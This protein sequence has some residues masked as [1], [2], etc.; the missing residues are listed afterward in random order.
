MIMEIGIKGISYSV[1]ERKYLV[2][3]KKDSKRVY[4][5]RYSSLEEAK[6]ALESYVDSPKTQSTTPI[7]ESLRA[8]FA[9]KKTKTS[10]YKTKSS[11]PKSSEPIKKTAT[12]TKKTKVANKPKTYQYTVVDE[13]KDNVIGSEA[14]EK[15]FVPTVENKPKYINISRAFV[16][17]TASVD[18]K[19]NSLTSADLKR[20]GLQTVTI[21]NSFIESINHTAAENNLLLIL[22]YLVKEADK[23]GTS[24][25]DVIAQEVAKL[26][27]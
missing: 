25:F 10:S 26:S 6:E 17:E 27:K 21:D 23:R 4:V 5:G 11:K 19:K 8:T 15:V 2:R 9:P 22:K 12:L 16:E 24:V 3:I 14:F 20:M 18:S 7:L 13:P 1:T